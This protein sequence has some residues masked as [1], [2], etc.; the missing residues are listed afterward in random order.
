MFY[1]FYRLLLTILLVS[2]SSSL[3]E[4][5]AH[6]YDCIS[7]VPFIVTTLC[8]SK[9]SNVCCRIACNMTYFGMQMRPSRTHGSGFTN[10]SVMLHGRDFNSP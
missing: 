7:N 3:V 9:V 8:I 2:I 10:A 5:K 1:L 4:E 6:S